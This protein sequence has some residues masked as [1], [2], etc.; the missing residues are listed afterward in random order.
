[1][2]LLLEIPKSDLCP[3]IGMF[4]E[5]VRESF[6][7]LQANMLIWSLAVAVTVQCVN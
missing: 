2:F 6:R 5:N 4:T 1:V 3:E 7:S